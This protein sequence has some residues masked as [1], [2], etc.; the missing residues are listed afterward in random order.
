VKNRGET[1][2]VSLPRRGEKPREG[3]YPGEANPVNSRG[4]VVLEGKELQESFQDL[5]DPEGGATARL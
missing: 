2:G 1:V 5:S 3:A 4:C